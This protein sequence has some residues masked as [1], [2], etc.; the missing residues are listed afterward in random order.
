LKLINWYLQKLT[1]Q[2]PSAKPL[3]RWSGYRLTGSNVAVRDYC[4]SEKKLLSVI[5][6][7]CIIFKWYERVW[8]FFFVLSVEKHFSFAHFVYNVKISKHRLLQKKKLK[9][10]YRAHVIKNCFYWRCG[11][12][13][14][15]KN[16]NNYK[17][18]FDWR[19]LEFC[20]LK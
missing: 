16:R 19:F 14:H 17:L 18:P 1:G 13:F 8:K 11:I 10:F 4:T 6:V 7:F 5:Q 15:F 2:L 12:F 9:I 3:L 20:F